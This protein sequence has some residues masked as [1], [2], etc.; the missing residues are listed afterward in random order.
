MDDEGGISCGD[1]EVDASKATG[2]SQMQN[3]GCRLR[4]TP[5]KV[6]NCHNLMQECG[7]IPSLGLL[8]VPFYLSEYGLGRQ[9][10]DHSTLFQPESISNIRLYPPY[11]KARIFRRLRQTRSLVARIVYSMKSGETNL[12]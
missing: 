11:T 4:S 1:C 3:L 10:G 6:V 2:R 8:E 9:V 5:E 7:T 12:S